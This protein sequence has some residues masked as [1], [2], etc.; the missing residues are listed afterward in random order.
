MS[1]AII[2]ASLLALCEARFNQEQL[3]Q[4][5]IGALSQFGSPGAA[6]TLAGTSISTLLAASNA[7]DKVRKIPRAVEETNL[8]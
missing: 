5:K 2:I 7:C 4:G 1:K 3:V 8:C 6:A